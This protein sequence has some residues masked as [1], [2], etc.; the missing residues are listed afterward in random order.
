MGGGRVM[1]QQDY[2]AL[3]THDRTLDPPPLESVEGPHEDC[4]REI[5]RLQADVERLEANALFWMARHDVLKK[6]LRDIQRHIDVM[7]PATRESS[8]VWQIAQRAL[9]PPWPAPEA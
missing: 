7:S 1:N 2:A 9:N 4:E 5:E 6:A 3:A 8:A